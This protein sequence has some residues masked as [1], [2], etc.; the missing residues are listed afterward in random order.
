MKISAM[1]RKTGALYALLTGNFLIRQLMRISGIV[2][3]ILLTT[4]QVLMATSGKGQDMRNDKVT[5]GLKDDDLVTALKRI[6]HQTSLRF[7]YRKADIKAINRLNMSVETRTIEQTLNELL[8][9]TFF[10]FRQIDGNIL[11]ERSKQQT[12]YA[13]EGRVVDVNHKAVA[14]ATISILK[15]DNNQKIQTSQADTGGYFK[16][17]IQEKGD[18][19][20]NISAVS[21]DSLSV[22]LTLSEKAIVQLP[23]II[24]AT[25]STQLKQVTVVGKKPLIEY[26]IDR[27]VFNVENSMLS[28]GV[29]AID[30]LR[31]TPR[32]EVTDNGFIKM[33]GK[34]ALRVMI[35]GRILNLSD[36]DVKNKLSTLRS[37]DIARIEIIPIPPS[38]YSAEGNSGMI[39]IILK[40]N[41]SLGWKGS[42]N[43]TYIQRIYAS[44]S[45][46]GNINYQ[47]KKLEASVS[48]TNNPTK[49][50]NEQSTLY[51]FTG[52]SLNT[53]KNTV[54]NSNSLSFNG[55]L[56]YKLNSR[57][58][59]GGTLN[60][61]YLNSTSNYTANS[62]Y[63][64][65]ANNVVDSTVNSNSVFIQQPRATAASAYYDY[66]MDGKGKKMELTY[67]YS[68]N[69]NSSTNNINSLIASNLS[70]KNNGILNV[71]D[72]NYR[73]N[74]IFADFELPFHFAKN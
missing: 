59:I 53:S 38:K 66:N 20:I 72:N 51:D 25:V 16:L 4:F 9:N 62:N 68:L 42:V 44:S 18:Y 56:K 71:A 10:S 49:N 61:S 12:A 54:Y 26:T 32:I 50:V 60:Y 57:M 73:I 70:E 63:I 48:V 47:S 46:S 8:N 19:I 74:S 69:T 30:V 58:E 22:G 31:E 6:E 14:F 35:D 39:N 37:D 15:A 65:K 17:A 11:I 36:E 55:V 43:S 5:I 45:Q 13:I 33:T 21:M 24:L 23:D 28:T 3:I 52:N 67:N 41:P 27:M 2:T 64:K 34:N 29:N 1:M 7:Y 40:R